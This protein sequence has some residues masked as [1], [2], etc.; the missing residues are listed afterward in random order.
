[1]ALSSDNYIPRPDGDFDAWVNQY[2]PAVDIWWKAQGLDTGELSAL[3]QA[4]EEWR[5]LYPTH[6]AAQAAA[7]GA[8][9]AKDQARQTLE[10]AIRPVTRFVQSYPATTNAD[11]ATMGISVR[12]GRKAG[13]IAPQ[14]RP[15]MVI[16][17]GGRGLHELRI[18]DESTPTRRSKPKGAQRAEVFLAIT[19]ANTPA[20]P[21]P[22]P[23]SVGDG[24]YRYMGSA[25]GG[26]MRLQFELSRAGQQ[27]HYIT[28]WV[29]TKGALG[30]WSETT[31]ATIAA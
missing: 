27:T 4:L 20:P 25:S 23:G 26:T 15:V 30:P 14:T 22:P 5:V 12:T 9:S 8:R 31:S 17:A 1:M 6:V 18:M 2:F 29:G 28:R 16:N 10:A 7:E 19:P 3:N 21:L 13:G 11:R 24:T